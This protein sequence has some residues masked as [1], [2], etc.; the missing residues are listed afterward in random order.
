TTPPVSLPEDK[1]R[2]FVRNPERS[3]SIWSSV[4]LFTARYRTNSPDCLCLHRIHNQLAV[5]QIVSQ[6][7]T[8]AHPHA[9]LLRGKNLVA[10]AFSR[11]LPLKLSEGQKHVECESTHRRGGIELL[12]HGDETDPLLIE[13]FNDAG[14]V[15]K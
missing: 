15:R 9:L 14:E 6:G 5:T 2:R 1:T 11:H 3:S 8:P 10:D 12:G 4:T 7:H 13:G